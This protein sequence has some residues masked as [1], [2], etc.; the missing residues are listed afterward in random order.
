VKR[1]AKRSIVMLMPL[2][3]AGVAVVGSAGPAAAASGPWHIWAQ[4]NTSLC[5]QSGGASGRDITVQPCSGNAAQKFYFINDG[6]TAKITDNWG[7]CLNIKGAVY[8]NNTHIISYKCSNVGNDVWYPYRWVTTVPN[9]YELQ[10][11]NAP[12]WMSMNVSGA[13]EKAGAP[14]ILYHF[15]KTY[16]N[17]LFSWEA[18]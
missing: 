4:S 18:F 3:T 8:A 1:M 17:S 2:L 14:V 5:F 12:G 16:K 7:Y 9:Y 10:A 13:V 15:E 11:L 6:L